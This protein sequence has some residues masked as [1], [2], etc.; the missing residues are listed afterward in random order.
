[1]KIFNLRKASLLILSVLFTFSCDKNKVFPENEDSQ[2]TIPKE[3]ISVKLKE[4]QNPQIG[5]VDITAK[6]IESNGQKIYVLLLPNDVDAE[7][8]EFKPTIEIS[9]NTTIIPES[10]L[11]QELGK[12]VFTENVFDLYQSGVEYTVTA[13]QDNSTK[14]YKVIAFRAPDAINAAETAIK[15]NDKLLTNSDI[16][17]TS[18]DD[19]NQTI[20][21]GSA[22]NPNLKNE[23]ADESIELGITV[24]F[25]RGIPHGGKDN[26]EKIPPPTTPARATFNKKEEDEN[27]YEAIIPITYKIEDIAFVNQYKAIIYKKS[28]TQVEQEKLI[29]TAIAPIKKK[30]EALVT[31]ANIFNN[32]VSAAKTSIIIGYIQNTQ[33]EAVKTAADAAVAKAYDVISAVT[34]LDLDEID[35]AVKSAIDKAKTAAEK[36]KEST[37]KAKEAIITAAAIEPAKFT[38]EASRE[39]GMT[40]IAAD[41]AKK[42]IEEA[43]EAL[44]L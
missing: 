27:T 20:T 40:C 44:N 11:A 33:V 23:V 21:F 24:E 4:S 2:S 32:E 42:A 37:E 18:V 38:V 41:E 5:G 7:I 12:I 3:I 6:V 8:K 15:A 13:T 9:E 43:N 16:T 26:Y 35:E 28:D 36:V 25:N 29:D 1:M 10:G 34:T 31:V 17:A 30:I 22:E 14:K 19:L 39:L